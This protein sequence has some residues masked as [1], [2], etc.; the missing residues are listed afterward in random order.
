MPSS[1]VPP[2]SSVAVAAHV[3]L[4]APQASSVGAATVSAPSG[5]GP[6]SSLAMGLNTASMGVP[7][8]AAASVSIS[9]AASSIPSSASSSS[10]GSAASSGQTLDLQIG[11]RTS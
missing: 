7:A 9:T 4:G 8:A 3:S 1:S 10:R 6:V 5:L 11:K 2:P